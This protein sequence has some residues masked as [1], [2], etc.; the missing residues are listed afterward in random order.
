MLCVGEEINI[1]GTT[2]ILPLMI[3]M[4]SHIFPSQASS[5]WLTV[6]CVKLLFYTVVECGLSQPEPG[7]KTIL[8]DCTQPKHVATVS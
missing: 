1:H 2:S 7:P 3:V 8:K 5:Y 6:F 4:L